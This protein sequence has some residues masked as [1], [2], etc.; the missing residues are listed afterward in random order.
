MFGAG[1]PQTKPVEQRSKLA[2]LITTG[3]SRR[4]AALT[5]R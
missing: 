5:R 1:L 2:C 3:C 4:S